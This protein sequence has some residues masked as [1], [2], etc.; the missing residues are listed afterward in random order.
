MNGSRRIEGCAGRARVR[1]R[2]SAAL[3]LG[4]VACGARAYEGAF[5]E[6][7]HEDSIL[8]KIDTHELLVTMEE[9]ATCWVALFLSRSSGDHRQAHWFHE[10]A[11]AWQG[12]GH[13]HFGFVDTDAPKI[14]DGPS[15]LKEGVY[16]WDGG[17]NEGYAHGSVPIGIR[18]YAKVGYLGKAF[19]KTLDSQEAMLEAKEWIAEQLK[20]MGAKQVP[21]KVRGHKGRK[22]HKSGTKVKTEL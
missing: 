1:M 9:D 8:E 22:W 3:V 2:V 17:P 20:E 6:A 13:L 15:L 16:E 11:K 18:L 21:S 14:Y 5:D 10:L 4:L 19:T 7:W 12:R